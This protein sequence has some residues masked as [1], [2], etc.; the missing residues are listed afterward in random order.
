MEITSF[1]LGMLAIV[2]VAM[3]AVIV[4]GI[5]KILKL[6]N[7]VDEFRRQHIQEVD[8]IYRHISE[9]QQGLWRQFENVGR[10]VTTVEKTIM[11]QIDR[12]R[13]ETGKSTHTVRTDLSG[14]ID[15]RIDKL[16]DTYFEHVGAKSKKEIING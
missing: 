7:H 12:V 16:I 14:Y 3:V 5:V 15:S 10:D 11:S 2:T 8:S 4:V 6:T 13:Q 9:N 1:V